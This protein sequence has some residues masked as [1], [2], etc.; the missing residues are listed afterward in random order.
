MTAKER[1]PQ[2]LVR[3]SDS[4]IALAGVICGVKPAATDTGQH[5]SLRNRDG[6]FSVHVAPE[7]AQLLGP[8]LQSGAEV[9]VLGRAGTYYHHR[10]R[11]NQVV[12]EAAAIAP[13][14]PEDWR[15]QPV[16]SPLLLSLVK[17]VTGQ[18]S[19]ALATLT[20]LSVPAEPLA[21]FTVEVSPGGTDDH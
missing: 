17:L 15:C 10:R 19:R 3:D 2:E 14:E 21:Q 5:F 8:A 1:Q 18:I 16:L 6:I 4:L 9:C 20:D 7:L 13:V 12:I 11:I